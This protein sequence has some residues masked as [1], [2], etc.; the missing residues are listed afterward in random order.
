MLSYLKSYEGRRKPIN[1][2][3][4]QFASFEFTVENYL[5]QFRYAIIVCIYEIHAVSLVY[6]STRTETQ[7]CRRNPIKVF[8]Q[9]NNYAMFVCDINNNARNS[10]N[11]TSL[12]IWVKQPLEYSKKMFQMIHKKP[13][14]S[15]LLMSCWARLKIVFFL[16]RAGVGLKVNATTVY[17][18]IADY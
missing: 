17:M 2:F 15:C 12:H 14:K 18:T 10:F 9:P 1:N 11:F 13:N 3:N 7:I 4:I 8:K 16:F 5:F 6:G